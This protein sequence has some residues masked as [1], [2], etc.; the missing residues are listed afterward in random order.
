[1]PAGSGIIIHPPERLQ[2]E[3][4]MAAIRKRINTDGST[5]F[6]VQ[7]RLKGHAPET[8]SFRRLTDARK[9]AQQTEAAIREGRHFP[10]SAARQRTL[11]D[12]IDRYSRTVLPHKKPNNIAVQRPQL[13][14]W[15][16]RLGHLR[17]ADVTPAV[18]AE[19]RDTL[20]QGLSPGTVRQYFL[21]ISHVFNVAVREWQWIASNPVHHVNK[22]RKP[23]G[24]VRH[25][26]DEERQRLLAACKGSKSPWLYTIVVL[27]LATG[28]RKTE[29]LS[30]RWSDVDLSRGSLTLYDTKNG[31]PRTVPLVGPAL[32]LLRQHAKVRRLDTPL[33][34]PSR[35]GPQLRDFRSAWVKARTQAG[36]EDFRFHDLRHSCASYLA[37]SGASLLD[38]A[39]VLGHKS[40]A[41]AQWYAHLS[42]QHTATV[43]GRMSQRIFTADA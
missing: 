27:A 26:S 25:L 1:M 23:Q 43:L 15:R 4:G 32:E 22:P 35:T 16:E 31:E 33:V 12:L 37:M 6:H 17:L 30:L 38:I 18:L 40:V 28:C 2:K 5:S 21:A 3:D 42:Q 14:V 11:A 8:A 29:L 19:Q 10:Q 13:A 7:I 36:L 39:T 24:R 9:W 41:M 20:S 34:F